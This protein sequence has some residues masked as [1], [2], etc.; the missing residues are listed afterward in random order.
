MCKKGRYACS[1]QKG[2]KSETVQSSLLHKILRSSSD[3]PHEEGMEHTSSN[4]EHC[5]QNVSNIFAI[6]CKRRGHSLA[7]GNVGA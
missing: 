5:E 7:K 4:L 6:S 2:A 3:Q 1:S